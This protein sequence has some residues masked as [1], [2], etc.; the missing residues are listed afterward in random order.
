MDEHKMRSVSIESARAKKEHQNLARACLGLHIRPGETCLKSSPQV[1]SR[2]NRPVSTNASSLLFNQKY[3]ALGSVSLF[4]A[5]VTKC[6]R[7]E[8]C[9]ALDFFGR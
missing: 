7:L 8:S 6:R 2:T 9:F 1:S 3:Q 4:S 5:A